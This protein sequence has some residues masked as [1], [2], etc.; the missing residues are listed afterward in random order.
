M[1]QGDS[2]YP[3][4]FYIVEDMLAIII[5]GPKVD[6]QIERVVPHLVDGGL[7]ILQYADVT[8]QFTEHDLEKTRNLNLIL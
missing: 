5:E 4:L 2:L 1:G 3:I 6:C 7:S 8:I